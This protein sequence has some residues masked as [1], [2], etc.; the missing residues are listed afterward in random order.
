MDR[1]RHELRKIRVPEGGSRSTRII[2]NL[3]TGRSG[4]IAI[5]MAI[6]RILQMIVPPH[7]EILREFQRMKKSQ[8][9]GPHR[10]FPF[11]PLE[12]MRTK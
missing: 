11:S 12:I 4:A 6:S 2:E 1:R 5:R 3:E 10:N 7:L 8:F 9:Q